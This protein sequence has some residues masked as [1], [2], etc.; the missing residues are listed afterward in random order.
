VSEAFRYRIIDEPRPGGLERFAL[1]PL[2][3][4]IVGNLLLPWGWLLF[5]WNALALN[6][7]QRNREIAYTA[8]AV[9]IYHAAAL[10]LDNLIA[11]EI[12]SVA[13][14]RYLFIAAVGLGFIFIARAYVSQAEM[15]EL[16]TYLRGA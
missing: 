16:R 8:L 9:G 13:P 11:A 4:F 2:L 5:V 15:N 12:I 14:A 1:P 6:G 7:P 10:L 3:I